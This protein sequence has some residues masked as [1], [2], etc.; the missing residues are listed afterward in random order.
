MKNQFKKK[1]KI[2][3]KNETKTQKKICSS[4]PPTS[5]SILC[6]LEPIYCASNF[7]PKNKTKKKTKKKIDENWAGNFF[8]GSKTKHLYNFRLFVST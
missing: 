6:P 7:Q 5:L 1:F 4:L 2:K 3:R 8:F